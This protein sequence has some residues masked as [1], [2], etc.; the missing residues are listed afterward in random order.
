VRITDELR[1][2]LVNDEYAVTEL[3]CIASALALVDAGESIRESDY[4]ITVLG[5][6][7]AIS[8][9]Y[10]LMGIA[11]SDHIALSISSTVLL[12]Y[13][14]GLREGRNSPE[15]KPLASDSASPDDLAGFIAG[16]DLSKLDRGE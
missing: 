14:L 5:A 4:E 1:K 2:R 9:R 7:L 3:A 12:A 15:H 16:L 11:Q 6:N 13:I 10:G 8:V